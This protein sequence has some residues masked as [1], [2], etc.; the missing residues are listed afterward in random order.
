MIES[1]KEKNQIC[2]RECNREI[3]QISRTEGAFQKSE[4]ADET[5]YIEMKYFEI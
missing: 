5:V 4:L 1:S 3:S 2:L